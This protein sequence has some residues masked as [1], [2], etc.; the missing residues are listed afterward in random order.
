MYL[1]VTMSYGDDTVLLSETI[2]TSED[3]NQVKV[4]LGKR[5]TAFHLA[6]KSRPEETEDLIAIDDFSMVDC[7]LPIPNPDGCSDDK[8]SCGNSKQILFC[9]VQ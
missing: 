8:F 4:Y 9:I 6:V 7:Q 2:H 5:Q 1:E 3:W